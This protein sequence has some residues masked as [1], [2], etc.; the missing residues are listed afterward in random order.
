MRG[1]IRSFFAFA[2]A[3]IG[4]RDCEEIMQQHKLTHDIV[5][6]NNTQLRRQLLLQEEQLKM[7][8]QLRSDVHHYFSAAT[9]FSQ[10]DVLHLLDYCHKLLLAN[11]QNPHID[12]LVRGMQDFISNITGIT[13]VASK[14]ENYDD[15][16][17]SIIDCQYHPQYPQGTIIDVISQG[18]RHNNGRVLRKAKVIVSSPEAYF[19][20][21]STP[22]Q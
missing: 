2:R 11:K 12:S 10:E 16:S 7:L 13:P 19:A 14:Q 4:T 17:T 20:H 6:K 15:S 8:Q 18:Y 3:R 1:L 9:S 21:V 22:P 5:Q